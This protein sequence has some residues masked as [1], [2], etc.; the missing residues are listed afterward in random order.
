MNYLAIVIAA[1]VAFVASAAWY[2]VL[3][4]ELLRLQTLYRRAATDTKMPA[5][6]I[7]AELLRSL[8]VAYVLAQLFV[9]VSAADWVATVQSGL[10][11]WIGFPLVL[12]AGS[13]VHEN[14]PWKLA[15][16]H[17]GDWLVKLILM[18]VILGVWR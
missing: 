2:I 5:W 12:L 1:A 6:K 16:I 10:W 7:F 13:V 3:G 8:I 18:T 17:A 11:L 14:V 4:R 15:A 9:P